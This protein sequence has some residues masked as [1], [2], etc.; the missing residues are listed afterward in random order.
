MLILDNKIWLYELNI[1]RTESEMYMYYKK[2]K[3]EY[4]L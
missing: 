3:H 2:L 1:I 4:I